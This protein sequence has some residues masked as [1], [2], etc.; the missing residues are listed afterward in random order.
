[1]PAGGSIHSPI[2]GPPAVAVVLLALVLEVVLEVAGAVL[3]AAAAAV[4][5]AMG[6]ATTGPVPSDP[7]PVRPASGGG[8]PNA[9]GRTNLC[10]A[11][12]ATKTK[13]RCMQQNQTL[14]KRTRLALWETQ[15]PHLL[16]EEVGVV[17]PSVCAHKQ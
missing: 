10:N 11:H 15:S 17:L 5:E 4:M 16:Q 8:M 2:S 7:V 9:P 13:I 3:D 6:L 12:R 14:S 1:M